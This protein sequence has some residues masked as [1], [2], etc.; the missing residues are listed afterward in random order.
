MRPS[1]LRTGWHLALLLMGSVSAC[2]CGSHP[3]PLAAPD[4]GLAAAP[5][6]ADAGPSLDAGPLEVGDAGPDAGL[7]GALPE[8]GA[9]AGQA[10]APDLD[11][12]P[13]DAGG[14]AGPGARKARKVPKAA[15][16]TSLDGGAPA[17]AGVHPAPVPV[18]VAQPEKPKEAE[19]AAAAPPAPERARCET[20]HASLI[21]GPKPHA[22][23]ERG[24]KACHE[25]DPERKGKCKSADGSAWD[26][27][28]DQ[29][30]LCL[31]CHDA[32]AA[33]GELHPA[34]V[35]GG[36]TACHDPHLS[37]NPFLMKAWP[38]EKNC[39]GCH[40]QSK[41]KKSVHTAVKQ[42]KCRE[43]HDPHASEL[44]PLLV[45]DKA[46]LCLKCHQPEKLKHGKATHTPVTEKRCLEC[47]DAHQADTAPLLRATGR[48]LC[49]KCHD[50][51]ASGP[52][53]ARPGARLDL[54]RKVVHQPLQG[55]GACQACHTQKHGAQSKSLLQAA[56][57][58]ETC[59]KCHKRFDGLAYP[60]GAVKTGK[61]TGC[62]E[63][64]S[65]AEAKL[66]LAPQQKEVCFLCHK[67]DLT[68]RRVIH[69]PIKEKGC[70]ACH[71]P[72]GA[73]NPFGLKAGEG[74]D[75]CYSCHKPVDQGKV[76]HV[77]LSRYGCERCHDPHGSNNAGLLVADV[78]T[79][80]VSCHEKQKGGDHV[81]STPP[82]KVLGGSDPRHKAREFS[83]ISCHNPHG[84]DYP[85]LLYFKGSGPLANCIYCHGDK[86]KKK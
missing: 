67:D 85:K 21:A 41:Q 17:D 1:G 74:K 39:L 54:E 29:P 31:N 64:H 36:C 76:P 15:L 77:A 51:N 40:E 44:R 18:K 70:G 16:D 60:H 27:T 25:P 65:S 10:G 20:C 68:G 47:H 12:G 62:H 37:K 72:H 53:A 38:V 66:L 32:T 81:G 33:K 13:A 69:K 2:T 79:L 28:T 58:A 26:L 6:L 42:G 5:A 46:S 71:D 50:K 24:C 35:S 11:A 52:A 75:L 14:D 56:S 30:G 49:L 45:A 59:F 8:P 78:N 23:G 80:C 34:I 7:D 55:K 73:E 43:C 57:A 19:P 84:S 22:V 48:A 4:A 63:P 86:S 3:E 9:D 82:H 61:C 83:C